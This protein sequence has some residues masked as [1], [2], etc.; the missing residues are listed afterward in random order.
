MNLKDFLISQNVNVPEKLPELA[1]LAI[2][3]NCGIDA[4]LSIE[5]P[6]QQKITILQICGIINKRCTLH[7]NVVMDIATAIHK[8]LK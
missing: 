8:A 5:F 2:G 6:E 4:V 7:H 1:P 3:Y